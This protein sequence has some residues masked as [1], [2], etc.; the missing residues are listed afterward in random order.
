M[1]VDWGKAVKIFVLNVN[2]DHDQEVNCLARAK[3]K[4]Q[5][6]LKEDS[7]HLLCFFGLVVEKTWIAANR[8][9]KSA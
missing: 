5:A 2:L 9:D 1:L 3:G 6:F 7:A 4:R 8:N